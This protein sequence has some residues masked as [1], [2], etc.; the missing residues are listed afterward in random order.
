MTTQATPGT[1]SFELG[2]P[3]SHAGLNLIPL[4]PIAS[5]ELEYI[6]LDEAVA[7]GL[8]VS[9]IG[10]EGIVELLALDNPLAVDVL[11]Y[12]GEE[13]VGAKQNRI[14][15]QT[16]LVAAQS[17]LKIPAKCV[18][19]GRWSH[20]TQHFAPAPRAAYPSL[21]R[22]Q[23]DGQGAV[24]AEVSAKAFRLDAHSPTEA[25]ESMYVSRHASLDEYA[26]ALPRLDGQSG[27]IVAIGGRLTCFD[28]VSRSDVFAGLYLKLLR[29]Y[30]LEA[31]EAPVERP[32][33]NSAL[34]RFL[35]ELELA[36]RTWRPA[37]GR[38]EEAELAGYA[39]GRELSV[40]GE[41]VALSAFPS[42]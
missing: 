11:L 17:T 19:R 40:D 13:L 9:E 42:R 25:A 30:A 37:I 18:E 29:G 10:A 39:I 41:I 27:V 1:L 23:R 38:G 28:Y 7:N 33:S 36:E 35:G 22:A 2:R 8:T 26:Q 20:R 21:R 3:H 31:I 24:W 4:F 12:E 6:G 14:L 34:G 32:L 5:P 16:I 15:E